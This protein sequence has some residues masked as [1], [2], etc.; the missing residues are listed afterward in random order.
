[1]TVTGFILSGAFSD[2]S[3]IAARQA[4]LCDFAKKTL[5]DNEVQHIEIADG[6]SLFEHMSKPNNNEDGAFV[7]IAEDAAISQT[8]DLT[9]DFCVSANLRYVTENGEFLGAYITSPMDWEKIKEIKN[10]RVLKGEKI[11]SKS[12]T[13]I[14]SER[15]KSVYKSLCE[16]NVYMESIDGVFISPLAQIGGGS[17][18]GNGTR[19][20][21]E[22][23]IG[24][25]CLLTGVSRIS[26]SKIGDGTAVQSG[27]ILDSVIGKNVSVGPFAYVR[28][29]S[30]ISDCV[31]VGDFV[32]IKNSSVGFGTKISH[33]TYVGDSD[34]GGGVNFGCGTVTVNYDGIHKHRTVI[35]DNVF[36]GCNTNLVAPVEVGGNAFIAAGSTITDN[37]PPESFA[38]ARQRQTTKDNYVSE[39]MPDMIKK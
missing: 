5:Y 23:V 11:T 16:N 6:G 3:D 9:S 38:I 29:G 8:E 33:L 12:F 2:I 19:I 4:L 28:P 21:G 27:V 20:E 10:T 24:Q 22:C 14:I 30:N 13:R 26:C 34:V 36:I 17:F 7:L 15:K 1:M 31:R 25:N 37:I 18:I 32:E 39:K 35:G